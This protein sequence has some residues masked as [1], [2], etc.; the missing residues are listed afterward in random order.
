MA[1]FRKKTVVI[2]AIRYEGN[3]NFNLIRLFIGGNIAIHHLGN[4]ELGIET[5]EGNMTARPG[6]WIIKGVQGEFYPCKD[7]IFRETYEPVEDSPDGD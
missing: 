2:E 7:S 3:D 5:L 1:K 4:Q 6:D